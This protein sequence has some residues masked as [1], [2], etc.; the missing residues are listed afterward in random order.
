MVLALSLTILGFLIGT[1]G[2]GYSANKPIIYTATWNSTNSVLKVVGQYWGN[3]QSVIVSNPA[4]G[5]ALGTVQS[6]K[7]GNWT[8]KVSNPATVPCLI[9]AESAQSFAQKKVQN[10]PAVCSSSPGTL[11]FGFNNLGMHCYDSDYSV[12]SILPPF[13]TVN[14]Q[15]V[16]RGTGG[17]KP[18]ILDPTQADL[19]YW[20]VK[21]E[22]GS[23]NKT[24]K[25]KTNFWDY[26]QQLFGV[27][28]PVDEGLTGNKMPGSGNF[29]QPFAAFDPGM[30]WFSASGIPITNWDSNNK[31]NTYPLMRIQPFDL[32][33]AAT[34]P[35]TYVVLPVSDEMHCSD[36]HAT[37]GVAANDATKTSYGILAWSSS[38]DPTIQYRENILIL[39][40]GKHQGY[41]L[42]GRKPVL[43]A[44]CHYSPALDL[45]G[46]GPQ[47]DQLLNP[48]LSYAVHG[49]HGKTL[50]GDIPGPGNPAVVPDTGI[51]TC[52]YCHPGQVTKCLRGVMSSAGIFCQDCHGG[53]LAVG[54]V[55]SSRTPWV[56]EP[57]CQSCHTG[58]AIDHLGNKFQFHI[59]YDPA[60]PAATPRVATNKRFAEE[61]G[62]L[63]RDSI[64]H[65][66]MACEACHGSTHA[67]WPVAKPSAN[68]NVAATQLQGHTGPIIE[69]KTCHADGLALTTNGPHSLH[70]VNT[71]AWNLNHDIFYEL[72]IAN[73]KACHGLLLEGTV[74]SRAAANRSLYADDNRPISIPKGTQ[75]SCTLCHENPLSGSD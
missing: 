5:D 47:G 52:Y 13:N 57:K 53:M 50:G 68:D 43:C 37:G 23:I 45:A 14:A 35:A 65:G 15:V 17:N 36:C 66:G 19:H 25:D 1:T 26:V 9:W 49:R 67:E 27:T 30:K 62:K 11:A 75:I 64:G 51:A 59:A 21:D 71:S 73:C 31:R 72:D 63:Y 12:F 7:K 56:N 29:P 55:Y 10:A 74:L 18:E 46:T 48:M 70:N 69:C 58:D 54:G 33:A 42:M 60:D 20:A 3:G 22:K 44:S 28:L 8:L 40:D 16:R 32:S 61:D 38:A 4:T 39:H 2:M 6:D 34:P 41:D 24:S